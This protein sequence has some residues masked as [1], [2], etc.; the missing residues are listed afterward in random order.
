MPQP[1]AEGHHRRQHVRSG[2]P[3]P[4][5]RP[6][7]NR[8]AGEAAERGR[9]NEVAYYGAMQPQ[10]QATAYLTKSGVPIVGDP[11][12]RIEAL[13]TAVNASR[14]LRAEERKPE[15]KRAS[16]TLVMRLAATGDV[17]ADATAAIWKELPGPLLEEAVRAM[18]GRMGATASELIAA[19]G[20]EDGDGIRSIMELGVTGHPCHLCGGEHD[21]RAHWLRECPAA[22]SA[23]AQVPLEK[24][25]RLAVVGHML[26]FEP[27][28]RVAYADAELLEL[29]KLDV[30]GSMPRSKSNA[31]ART[32]SSDGKQHLLTEERLECLA[33]AWIDDDA[34]ADGFP[35]AAVAVATEATCRAAAGLA[36]VAQ[37]AV[38]L[39]VW[40]RDA[41]QIKHEA[42]T[43][44]LT[45]ATVFATPPGAVGEA[46][47]ESG[48]EQS[49]GVS[50]EHPSSSDPRHKE[51]RQ[52]PWDANTLV[53][54]DEHS[55]HALWGVWKK[56]EATARSGHCVLVIVQEAKQQSRRHYQ[57]MGASEIAFFPA[58]T[59]AFGH[60][61]GWGDDPL[62]GR[63]GSHSWTQSMYGSVAPP[64]HEPG[65][66][67]RHPDMMNKRD[68]H[69]G[70]SSGPARRKAASWKASD[71]PSC[72]NWR[73]W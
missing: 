44:A 36:I 41:L 46:W 48:G 2:A 18:L 54:V 61:A 68:V 4:R 10:R 33:K 11:F 25:A 21:S 43:S 15:A 63:P 28:R 8:L 1:R 64:R 19:E 66:L 16:A 55:D 26:W 23:L 69:G 5:V 24:A 35:H 51:W 9:T 60:A 13:A 49:W 17:D 29:R 67:P 12:I 71:L 56:V 50:V 59:I 65:V 72:V 22:A 58:G 7:G 39:R 52:E 34:A 38:E 73:C 37:V 62:S 45:F 27:E 3:Q 20:C 47:E 42:L 31:H 30:L 57:N 32:I 40:L 14:L 53:V 70:C 6:A